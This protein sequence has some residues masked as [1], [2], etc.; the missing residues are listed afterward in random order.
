VGDPHIKERKGEKEKIS[1]LKVS[2][3]CPLILLVQER[4][5]KGKTAGS[6]KGKGL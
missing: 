5:R 4:L 3:P 6:G 1:S 2:R